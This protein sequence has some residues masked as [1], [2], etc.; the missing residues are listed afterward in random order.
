MND[1]ERPKLPVGRPEALQGEILD[2]GAED[3]RVQRKFDQLPAPIA[4]HWKR[5]DVQ[6]RRIVVSDETI[7]GWPIEKMVS[8]F[9]RVHPEYQTPEETLA[10]MDR[11]YNESLRRGPEQSGP[12]DGGTLQNVTPDSKEQ[13]R[14]EELRKRLSDNSVRRLTGDR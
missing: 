5:M 12:I 1:F 7:L 9:V 14:I 13:K 8:D 4:E 11:S 6:T 10:E 3:P 2:P